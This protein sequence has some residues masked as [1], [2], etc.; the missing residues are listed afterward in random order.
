MADETPR[1]TLPGISQYAGDWQLKSSLVSLALNTPKLLCGN[2]PNR[3]GLYF[4]P[5]TNGV[6][7]INLTSNFPTQIF[8]AIQSTGQG[9]KWQY[10]LD[11]GMTQVEWWGSTAA[12]NIFVPVFEIIYLPVRR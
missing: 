4:G 7:Y 11:G 1:M 8:C 3:F 10:P 9:L 6:Y 12:N 2:N 5:T